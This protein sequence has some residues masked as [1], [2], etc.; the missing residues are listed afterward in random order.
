MCL[1]PKLKLNV[2]AFLLL[3]GPNLVVGQTNS[4]SAD[5]IGNY[6]F[7]EDS[8]VVKVDSEG[9]KL[10]SFSNI[11]IGNPTSIDSSDPFRILVFYQ[12]AQTIVFLNNEANALGNPI[13]ISDLGLGEVTQVCR[14]SRGGVMLLH[15]ETQEIIRYNIHLSKA[16]D[17]FSLPLNGSQQSFNY[18]VERGGFLYLGV[19][20]RKIIKFD[21]YGAIIDKINIDF[22]ESFRIESNFIITSKNSLAYKVYLMSSEKKT[23]TFSCK[24]GSLPV[25]INDDLHC[26]D[27][28]K[29]VQC[30]K[31]ED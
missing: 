28:H 13:L 7:F 1:N 9:K 4:L 2:L 6:W 29:F 31:I 5:G 18:M 11:L 26:F 20:N 27:G 16:L 19:D 22:D 23:E 14:S 25:L 3:A 30:K 15:R 12:A 24:C 17:R 10:A 21:P 8:K